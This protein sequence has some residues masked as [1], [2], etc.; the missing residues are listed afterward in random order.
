MHV[1]RERPPAGRAWGEEGG[2]EM[3]V[4][5]AP[6]WI[7]SAAP[8]ASAATP[9]AQ[10]AAGSGAPNWQTSKD[11]DGPHFRDRSNDARDRPA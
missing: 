7:G 3:G 9:A 4:A 11:L 8:T 6:L 5:H 1:G 2:S 10:S